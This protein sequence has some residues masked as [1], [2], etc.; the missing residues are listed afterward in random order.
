MHDSSDFSI[1]DN[2]GKTL[3]KSVNEFV[4]WEIVDALDQAFP[5]DA[6]HRIYSNDTYR[7]QVTQR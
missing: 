3:A 2:R 4:M 5:A 7:T 6:P 1:T